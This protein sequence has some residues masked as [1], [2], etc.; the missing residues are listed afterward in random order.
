MTRRHRVLLVTGIVLGMCAAALTMVNRAWSGRRTSSQLRAEVAA[1][2]TERNTLKAKRDELAA[3]D[4]QFQDLPQTPVKVGI[5]TGLARD[6]IAKVLTGFADQ[7]S[8][9]LRNLAVSKTGTITKVVTLG[10]YRLRVNADRVSARLKPGLPRVAFGGHGV[11]IALPVS[12]TSGSGHA[13]V[14]LTWDGRNV[15]G[16][17][18]GDLD[19]ARNVTATVIP[20]TYNLAGRLS[21]RATATQIV[22]TPKIPPLRIHVRFKPSDESW[23]AFQQ[24]LD[25]KKGACGFV[26]DHVDVMGAVRDAI[27][28]G[29]HVTLPFD[30]IRPAALPVGIQPAIDVKGRSLALSVQV[31]TLTFTKDMIWLGGDVSVTPQVTGTAR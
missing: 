21:L 25:D 20:A 12:V 27:G 28:R 11:A 10:E 22:L 29:F 6:L 24:I 5:P 7:A 8:I 3:R 26:L 1:L 23:A 17:L 14:R 9:E 2:Q 30:R 31:G 16:A 4:S 15:A 19:I 18:C 13:T